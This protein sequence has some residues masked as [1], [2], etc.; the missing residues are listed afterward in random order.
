VW[1]FGKKHSEGTCTCGQHRGITL[2]ARDGEVIAEHICPV[3]YFLAKAR[4]VLEE[5][6]GE[7]L[8]DFIDDGG[9]EKYE[10][11]MQACRKEEGESGK[12]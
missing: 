8:R 6:G 11:L 10:Q 5:K 2:K 1:F 3:S 9:K 12:S 4:T 7:A